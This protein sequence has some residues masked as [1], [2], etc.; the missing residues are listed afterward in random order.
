[1][2]PRRL[3]RK[4]R[5]RA[6]GA[7]MAL[8]LGLA[9]A[10][11][12]LG[13]TPSLPHEATQMPETISAPWP[14]S[15]GL[16]AWYDGPTTR[17]PHGVLGDTVEA[18]RLS[19]YAPGATTPCATQSFELPSELVFEDTAPRLADL[20]GD[21]T[22]EII[23]VQSHQRLGAQ[24]AVYGF[25]AAGDRLRQIAA[26][27]HIGRRNRWLAPVGAAD[28][29]GDGRVEIAYIDRPHLAK[30]LRVWRFEAGALTEVAALDG[31]SNHRIGEPFITGGLRDC[32]SGPELITAD[33]DWRRVMATRLDAGTLDSR[34]LGPFSREA[35]ARAL[36][37]QG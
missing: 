17:Y 32:G 28:L 36:A 29:D 12:A 31:L 19:A 21:G 7:S 8:C 23:V 1:M 15:G 14:G 25:M 24:L 34:D 33:A 20:D 13:C 3:I 4:V 6:R 9:G 27:P 22:P 11:A 37:C 18:T 2:A 26:T 10:G 30:V 16:V 35:V 5:A